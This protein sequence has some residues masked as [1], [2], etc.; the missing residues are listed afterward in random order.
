MYTYVPW[1]LEFFLL[2]HTFHILC[3]MT[4][5][6]T[7]PL[8]TKCVVRGTTFYNVCIGIRWWWQHVTHHFRTIMYHRQPNNIFECF[9]TKLRTWTVLCCKLLFSHTTLRFCSCMRYITLRRDDSHSTPMLIQT[10]TLRK[11]CDVT[12]ALYSPD[13]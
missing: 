13:K 2:F 4:F 6:M 7:L 12:F 1:Q 8:R 3:I 11:L 5:I 10:D 9:V